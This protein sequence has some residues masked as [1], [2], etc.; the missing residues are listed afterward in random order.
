M[1]CE[2]SEH[3]QSICVSFGKSYP[4]E[5]TSATEQAVRQGQ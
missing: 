2:R 1:F 4:I 5:S 3:Q